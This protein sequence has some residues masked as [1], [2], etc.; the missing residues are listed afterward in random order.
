MHASGNSPTLTAQFK[1]SGTSGHT[2]VWSHGRP[3]AW[4][5]GPCKC[6]KVFLLQMLSKTFIDKVFMHHFEK[7]SSASGGFAPDFHRGAAPKSCRG[8]SVLQIPSLPT[9]EK[10]PVGAHVWFHRYSPSSLSPAAHSINTTQI[11]FLRSLWMGLSQD[12]KK[13]S[14]Y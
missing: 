4:A 11:G 8:T 10:N 5:R 6:W 3:Q 14:F 13:L 9:P 7:M 1:I 2:V 12:W